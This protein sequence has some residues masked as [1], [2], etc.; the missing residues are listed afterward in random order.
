MEVKVSRLTSYIA[1]IFKT[2]PIMMKIGVIGEISNL[3][4]HGS[5]SVFFT[6]KDEKAS[7]RC[8]MWQRYASELR[9]RLEDGME[10]TATGR[11]SV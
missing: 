2:D 4:Y 8:Q 11:V 7:I 10:I 6:L 9:Y 3:K 1:N 5:G